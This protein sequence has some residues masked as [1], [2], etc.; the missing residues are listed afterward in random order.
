[1]T[2]AAV[3]EATRQLVA[4]ADRMRDQWAEATPEVRRDDLWAPL[5][6]AADAARAALT[7][8]PGT[9]TT[10]WLA[11]GALTNLDVGAQLQVSAA[12]AFT[13]VLGGR[14][15]VAELLAVAR[16]T[17][18]DARLTVGPCPALPQGG[19]LSCP[20]DHPVAVTR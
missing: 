17:D 10:R 4:A 18:G 7:A 5:H 6:R 14:D 8:A 11:A 12:G 2:T 9:G 19:Q 1:M 16:G 3:A 13:G 20:L 15:L